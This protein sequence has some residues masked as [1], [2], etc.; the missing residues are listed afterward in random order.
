MT[1]ADAVWRKPNGTRAKCLGDLQVG[2]MNARHHKPVYSSKRHLEPATLWQESK[3]RKCR[4]KQQVA[5]SNQQISNE[6]QGGSYHTISVFVLI[7]QIVN[8]AFPVI[9]AGQAQ[10]INISGGFVFSES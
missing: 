9:N 6:G 2:K 3:P 10:Q 8:L 7:S 5:A 4:N 1:F